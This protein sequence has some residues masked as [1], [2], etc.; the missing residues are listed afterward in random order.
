MDS[1]FDLWWG[2]RFEI[3]ALQSARS[4]VP[5]HASIFLSGR[6]GEHL[7]RLTYCFF[8]FKISFVFA[9]F[10]FFFKWE[11]KEGTNCFNRCMYSPFINQEIENS[12]S[13][14]LS[15][16][17]LSRT[18]NGCQRPAGYL[19]SSPA[20]PSSPCRVKVLHASAFNCHANDSS[21]G[22][23]LCF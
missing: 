20:K 4:W 2:L 9:S 6:R 1:R 8:C 10:L 14:Q 3:E 19:V 23:G 11:S 7:E 12:P 18:D 13:E 15:L 17:V 5:R 21:F 22:H 16:L